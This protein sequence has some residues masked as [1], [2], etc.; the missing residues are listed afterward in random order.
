MTKKIKLLLKATDVK[1]KARIFDLPEDW[2]EE[3][4]LEDQNKYVDSLIQEMSLDFVK[5]ELEEIES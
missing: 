2:D 3:W 4:C 5:V 1:S